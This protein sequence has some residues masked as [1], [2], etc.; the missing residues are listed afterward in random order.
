MGMRLVRVIRYPQAETTLNMLRTYLISTIAWANVPELLQCTTLDSFEKF[1]WRDP[2]R[3]N[4]CTP[5]VRNDQ[6]CSTLTTGC[7]IGKD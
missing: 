5:C 7:L 2:R 3:K 1:S 4:D 6:D